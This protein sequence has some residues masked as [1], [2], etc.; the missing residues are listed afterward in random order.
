MLQRCLDRA[1]WQA[2]L[3]CG[4]ESRTPVLT[5]L[6]REGVALAVSSELMFIYRPRPG[7]SPLGDAMILTTPCLGEIPWNA[8][9]CD[10]RCEPKRHGIVGKQTTKGCTVSACE[11]YG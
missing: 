10:P 7:L 9:V 1:V 5:N 8:R 11:M 6:G 3:E 4:G 2:A